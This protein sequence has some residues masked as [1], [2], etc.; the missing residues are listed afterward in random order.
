MSGIANGKSQK[1]SVPNQAKQ[2]KQ[3]PPLPVPAS[4]GA[5]SPVISYQMPEALHQEL[6]EMNAQGT[7]IKIMIADKLMELRALEAAILQGTE[8]VKTRIAGFAA[9]HGVDLNNL[10]HGR[11]NFDF[12][13]GLLTKKVG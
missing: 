11:W 1:V 3:A 2:L 13:T 7:Q 12:P 10:E 8:A 9:M 4:P 5:V 6:L